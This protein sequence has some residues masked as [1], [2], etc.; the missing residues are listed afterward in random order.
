MGVEKE[1]T[2]NGGSF[3]H[4]FDWTSK[5][6]KKLFASKSDLPGTSNS[7]FISLVNFIFIVQLIS[8]FVIGK[9]FLHHMQSH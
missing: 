6:R 8:S 7:V 2:K 3:F 4:L 1:G 5:S 9:F